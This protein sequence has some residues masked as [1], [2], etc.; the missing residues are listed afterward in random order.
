M[1]QSGRETFPEADEDHVGIQ[2]PVIGHEGAAVGVRLADHPGLVGAAVEGILHE[3]FERRVLLLDYED[4]VEAPGEGADGRRIEWHR[5]PHVEE[6][7]ACGGDLGG[8]RE[9]EAVQG[10]EQLVVG[11]ATGGQADPGVRGVNGRVVETVSQ[12]VAAYQ[13]G[14]GLPEVTFQLE[15]VGRQEMAV[16]MVLV[17][18]AV[19][20][21]VGDDRYDVLRVQVH[22]AV[23]VGYGGHDLHCCPEARDPRQGDGV[24]SKVQD[25]LHVARIE[26]R[27]VEVDQ[28]GVG[29]G[30]QRGTLGGRVVTH[31]CDGASVARRAGEDSVSQCIA[32]T[33]QAGGLAVPDSE[34][35]VVTAVG[36]LGDE[37]RAH[38]GRCGQFLVDGRLVHDGQVG[39]EGGSPGDL[40]V[41]ASEGGAL[42]AGDEG[43]RVQPVGAVHP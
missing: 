3:P 36:L 24:H 9:T 8:C 41:E 28:G 4:L 35:A 31:D 19:D 43:R 29:T 1:R 23:P 16:G 18:P 37:L 39:D 38:D 27:H 6:P 15:R 5:D 2:D 10:V 12:G 20:R 33:V 40:N 25:L 34:H 21:E 30:R 32:G 22:G 13:F 26:D 17:G 7:D 14:A 11:E 42:V